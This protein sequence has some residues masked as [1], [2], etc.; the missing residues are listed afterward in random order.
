M[1]LHTSINGMVYLYICLYIQ[2]VVQWT[3][4]YCTRKEWGQSS[5]TCGNYS[6]M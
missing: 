3:E 6:G 1:L 4:S 2:N 5:R